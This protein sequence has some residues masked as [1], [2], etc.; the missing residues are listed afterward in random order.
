MRQAV[1][2]LGSNLG[3]RAELLR[4]ALADLQASDGIEVL[5][6][7]PVVVTRPVGGPEGQPDFLNAVLKVQTTLGPF[8][9]LRTC[10]RIEDAHDRVREVQWGP[11]TLD[12]D[13]ID[14]GGLSMDEPTLTL[15]HPRARE[16]AFV[17]VPWSMIDPDATLAGEPVRE[18]AQRAPDLPGI[19][20]R[21]YPLLTDTAAP[22]PS[23][24]ELP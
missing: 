9:L 8:E 10:Q 2:A 13:I 21:S 1:I 23:D 4:A 19:A 16:R 17:L 18:L 5:G 24:V 12:V 14:F 22:G 6:A 20:P 11:R 7:S 3:D 15:P